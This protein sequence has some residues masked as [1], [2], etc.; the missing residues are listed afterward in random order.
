MNL[1]CARVDMI[2]PHVIDE[3]KRYKFIG[4]MTSPTN[5]SDQG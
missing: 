3:L 1:E 5:L 2:L 4:D